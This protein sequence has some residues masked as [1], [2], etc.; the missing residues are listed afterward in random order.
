MAPGVREERAKHQLFEKFASLLVPLPYCWEGMRTRPS[1]S[2]SDMACLTQL[3]LLALHEFL[4][5]DSPV[6]AAN[7]WFLLPL[8]GEAALCALYAPLIK[9]WT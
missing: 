9:V 2:S 7:L 6:Q 5:L 4:P 3:M 1:P 8:M